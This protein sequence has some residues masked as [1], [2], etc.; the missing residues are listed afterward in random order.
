MRDRIRIIAVCVA[1]LVAHVNTSH[2]QETQALYAVVDYI[3]TDDVPAY[4][5]LERKWKTLHQEMVAKGVLMY[6]GLFQVAYPRGSAHSYNYAAVRIYRDFSQVEDVVQETHYREQFEEINPEGWADFIST[7]LVSREIVKSEI[8]ELVS[9]TGNDYQA[10]GRY[11]EV[12]YMDTPEGEEAAYIAA[13]NK[14][15]KPMQAQRIAKGLMTGWDL[16][17]LKYPS[18]T[19]EAYDYVTVN[20]FD[21]YSKL[22]EP[23]YPAGVITGAHPDFTEGDFERIANETIATRS[24]VQMQLWIRIDQTTK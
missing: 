5:A 12:D 1:V 16:W 3:Y 4:V 13:E 9:T 14:Y 18:G 2:G 22:S 17:G 20:F 21:S 7:T 11:V 24:M 10:M 15:W 8:F 23:D 6:W 19:S